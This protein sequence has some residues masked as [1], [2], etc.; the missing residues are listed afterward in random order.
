MNE[1]K[2]ELVKLSKDPTS[3]IIVITTTIKMMLSP[4]VLGKAKEKIKEE[5][6]E[7]LNV[8]HRDYDGMLLHFEDVKVLNEKNSIDLDYQGYPRFDVE[9]KAYVFQPK[10]GLKVTCSVFL[11]QKFILDCRIFDRIVIKVP[12][13]T[14]DAYKVGD[15]LL[16]EL[17]EVMHKNFYTKLTGQ[18]ISVVED[19]Q[20]KVSNKKKKF[21]ENSAVE[22]G[23]EDQSEQPSS[24]KSK[25]RKLEE[26][27]PE[28]EL[29]TNNNN[30]DDETQIVKSKKNKKKKDKEKL[31]EKLEEDEGF[32]NAQESDQERHKK[33]KKKKKERLELVPAHG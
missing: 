2:D 3:G 17:T 13:Q 15:R 10:R 28:D 14:R 12:N 4:S 6:T 11:P 27:P 29:N 1:L 26:D 7:R 33:H 22:N 32:V 20:N 16:V 23:H 19:K 18:F 21:L 8:Y 25:K 9:L 5:L 30:F 31:E 24:K